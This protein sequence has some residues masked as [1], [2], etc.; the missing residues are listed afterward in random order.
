MA[1]VTRFL[2]LLVLGFASLTGCGGEG[3]SAGTGGTAGSGGGGG[4]A[5]GATGCIADEDC[6]DADPCTDD[7]CGESGTCEYAPTADGASCPDGTCVVG[8][9]EPVESVFPCTEQGLLDAVALGGG[10]YGFSCDGPQ[11]VTTSAEILIEANVILD[12]L[13]KLTLD[14][15][16]Q[17]RLFSV[18]RGVTAELRRLTLTGGWASEGNGGAVVSSG[19]LTIV[20]SSVV[21]NAASISGGG[22]ANFG[23]AA[24]QPPGA[25]TLVATTVSENESTVDGGGVLNTGML[26]VVNSTISGNTAPAGNGGGGLRNTGSATVTSST[27]SG[28]LAA[29]DG[30]GIVNSNVLVLENSTVSGNEASGNGG[31]IRN[32]SVM[33]IASCTIASNVASAGSGIDNGGV[34]MAMSNTVVVG[35]CSGTPVA[36]DGYNIESTGNSCG[37]DQPTDA[38][39]VSEGALALGAL[40]D[41]GGPTS[42]HALGPASVAVDAIPVE[43]CGTDEDQRGVA[44]PQGGMCDIGSFELE[45]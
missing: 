12:G 11:T 39:D 43:L 45:P 21:G 14:G 27:V 3:G 24:T 19:R 4:G 20:D 13:G 1:A 22:I 34:V 28:N 25:M 36:S 31:G 23:G 7:I 9:C 37:L 40:A 26:T 32:N 35:D 16:G 2:W 10:P 30:G 17:H 41:N 44:R 15:G 5:G 18:P 29:S 42:T 8:L 38:V 6:D 33:T